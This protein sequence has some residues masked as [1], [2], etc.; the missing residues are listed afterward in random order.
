VSVR[1]TE[2]AYSL[3]T[4][5]M[6]EQ[7]FSAPEK[8]YPILI[9]KQVSGMAHVSKESDSLSCHPHVHPQMECAMPGFTPWSQSIIA[10]WLVFISRPI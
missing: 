2:W 1:E 9:H 7:G 5:Q 4:A 8:N 10:V 6:P 3:L